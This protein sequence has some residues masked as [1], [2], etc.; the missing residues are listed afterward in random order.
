MSQ[1]FSLYADLS[2]AEKYDGCFDF[3]DTEN[4]LD[5]R[6][7]GQGAAKLQ[8]EIVG[9]QIDQV[10]DDSATP[11]QWDARPFAAHEGCICLGQVGE[12]CPIERGDIGLWCVD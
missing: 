12:T 5:P 6:Q 9:G 2:V 4:Y 11:W 3:V 7:E 1:R 10:P 8:R